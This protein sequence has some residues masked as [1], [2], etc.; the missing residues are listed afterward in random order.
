M[1]F[2]KKGRALSRSFFCG[3]GMFR[4]GLFQLLMSNEFQSIQQD[5]R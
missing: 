1:N 5:Y 3:G 4:V 2:N